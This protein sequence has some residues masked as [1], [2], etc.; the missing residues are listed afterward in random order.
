MLVKTQLR[1]IALLPAV[2]ALL[3]GSILWSATLKVDRARLD[4]DQAEKA[5]SYNFE[6]NVLTQ[7][8]LLFGGARVESQLR[9][10]HRAMGELLAQMPMNDLEERALIEEMQRTHHELGTFYDMLLGSK[11]AAREMIVGAL[12]VKT[13][14]LRSLTQ[15]LSDLQLGQLMDFQRDADRVIIASAIV[16][17][18]LSFL[19]LSLMARRLIRGIKQLGEGVTRVAA[20]DLDHQITLATADELGMVARSFNSMSRKLRDSTTSIDK[21]NAEVAMRET[22]EAEIRQL[23]AD[24]EARVQRRT[25]D[26]EAANKE[27]E[28]F[29]YS[30]SHDLRAPLRA[31]DG[32][33]RKVV[34]GYGDKLDDEGRR[35]LQVIRDN[36]QRMGQLIDDLL[37]FSRMGRREMALQPLDMEALVKSV[38][39]ELRAA[40]PQRQ[41]ELTFLPLPS[42]TGDAAMLR[43]VWV[44]LLTNAL[45]F[46]RHRAIA[47]IEVGGC[48]ESSETLY[49]V[50]DDGAGFDMQYADKLFGVFQRLHRQDEFEGTGVGLAIAQRILH[51]HNG[52]IWGEGKPGEGAIFRFALPP[53]A[54][55]DEISGEQTS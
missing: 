35:Q 49:W 20:G 18:G 45:K 37:S 23:N 21:L 50:K 26:L 30:V 48:T 6:L 25:A 12:L 3:I 15:Q 52:R 38:V 29:A 22:A 43:Q 7:E 10:R 16:A 5:L 31:I 32:F 17:A 8:Y 9:L 53:P 27:L 14:D 19:L 44:N 51:R 42:V 13:Q 24:L 54:K 36:A 11:A 39:D 40:E 34:A 41:I 28:A 4:A 1:L 33:S 2:F 55:V 46:S 47:H